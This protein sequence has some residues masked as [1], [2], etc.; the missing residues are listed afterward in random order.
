VWAFPS[1]AYGNI[2][3][4]LAEDKGPS[5]KVFFCWW[6]R[7]GARSDSY[8]LTSINCSHKRWYLYVSREKEK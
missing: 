1:P 8:G 5:Y 3:F 6:E 7:F 2:C 4:F